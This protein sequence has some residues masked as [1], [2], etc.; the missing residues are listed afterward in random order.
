MVRNNSE[1]QYQVGSLPDDA[2]SYVTRDADQAFYEGLR[3]G[4]F[5]YVLN[6]RQMAPFLHSVLA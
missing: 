6:S 4:E 3:A 2:R 5:C 1:Y